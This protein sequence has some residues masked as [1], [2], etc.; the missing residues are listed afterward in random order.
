MT[1]LSVREV[2]YPMKL[3]HVGHPHAH[4][5][6]A[7]G[8]EDETPVYH[9]RHV[10][11]PFNLR[12]PSV[13]VAQK[14]LSPY[15][16][17]IFPDAKD[18]GM[19][20]GLYFLLE[21]LPPKPWPLTVGGLPV[22]VCTENSGS[23][24]LFPLSP[25]GG[26]P[27]AC[28]DLALGH[29]EQLTWSHFEK[30]GTALIQHLSKEHP[31][32]EVSEIL[33]HE[34]QIFQVILQNSVDL[35][36][37]R[38]KLPRKIAG[39]MASYLLDSDISRP[40]YASDLFAR[41]TVQP[42]PSAQVVDN[43]AYD[44]LRPGVMVC[45]P[46]KAGW[47]QTTTGVLIRDNNGIQF[48]TAASHGIGD[49]GKV[50]YPPPGTQRTLGEPIMEIPYTDIALVKLHDHVRFHNQ[51][52]DDPDGVSPTF[53][54]LFGE[55]ATDDLLRLKLYSVISMNN[56][57]TG[58]LDGVLSGFSI[59]MVPPECRGEEELEWI[60]YKWTFHGDDGLTQPP[61]GV[62]GSVIWDEDGVV[63]GFYRFHITEGKFAGFCVSV[64]ASHL[65]R[66]GQGYHLVV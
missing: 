45:S 12:D 40:A 14:E 60:R 19:G 51:P 22:K 17:N 9:N 8:K 10:V 21:A 3:A 2:D 29:E 52:F 41:R 42:D 44:I 1:G 30:I 13:K 47:L 32:I 57:W 16:Y 38:P 59:R 28:K 39:Y 23:V 62:C 55:E 53:S 7:E 48:M 4:P 50:C 6:R 20:G 65:A 66:F 11:L 58:H 33:A 26:G 43:T 46:D 54:R 63:Q 25:F 15:L 24:T 27:H 5:T 56:P 31:D 37:Q 49:T 64:S 61:P 34:G 18:V 36:A 35:S